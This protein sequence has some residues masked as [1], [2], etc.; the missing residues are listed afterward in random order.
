L[1]TVRSADGTTLAVDRSGQGP[2]VVIVVGAFCD[3]SS[4]ADLVAALSSRFTVY[5]YDRRGRGSST[6]TLPYAIEREAEDLDAVARVTGGP[7]FVYGHSSGAAI[8]LETAAGGVPMRGLVVYEPPY[9]GEVREPSLAAELRQLVSSGRRDDAAQRFLLNTGAPVEAVRTMASAPF[10]PRMVSLAHTLA[11]DV[12]LSDRGSASTE[13]C[14]GISV[15]TLALA[16]SDSPEWA[17]KAVEAIAAAVPGGRDR[18]LAGQS[19]N[20]TVEVIAPLLADFF[21]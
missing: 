10:W 21:S 12:M 3:R 4:G 20:P 2:A 9:L 13:W 14:A 16:G 5:R 6:D 7:P 18:I 15:P 8:A 19:H 11:Y 1:R 17:A